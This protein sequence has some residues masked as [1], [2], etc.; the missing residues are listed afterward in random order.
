MPISTGFEKVGAL[1]LPRSVPSTDTPSLISTSS[2]PMACAGVCCFFQSAFFHMGALL[3]GARLV[4]GY[5]GW[6]G[7][8]LAASSSS[9]LS[10]RWMAVPPE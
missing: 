7:T 1:H 8:C 2:S 6:W 5:F 9:V 4:W 3:M 10:L